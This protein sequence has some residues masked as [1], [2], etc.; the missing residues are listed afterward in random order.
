MQRDNKISL[1]LA[2]NPKS[3]NKMKHINMINNYLRELIKEDK[4]KWKLI[5]NSIILAN[6]LT[7]ALLMIIFKKH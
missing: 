7:K 2:K 5:S 4:L 1:T 3:Q 6:G